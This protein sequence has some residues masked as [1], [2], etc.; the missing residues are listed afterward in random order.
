M[1]QNGS[2]SSTSSFFCFLLAVSPVRLSGFRTVSRVG[3]AL[4]SG[5]TARI[6]FVMELLGLHEVITVESGGD[7]L[8]PAAASSLLLAFLVTDGLTGR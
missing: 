3:A 7:S 1:N 5:E 4:A 8:N 6:D 2:G